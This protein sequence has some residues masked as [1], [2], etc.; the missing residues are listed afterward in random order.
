V[1]T[2]RVN[3][4]YLRGPVLADSKLV[5][6][7]VPGWRSAAVTV[8]HTSETVFTDQPST[9]RKAFLRTCVQTGAETAT[10]SAGLGAALTGRARAASGAARSARMRMW[11]SMAETSET[12]R[13]DNAQAR[14]LFKLN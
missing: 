4:G 6:L 2:W 9:G 14:P 5:K 7:F 11:R 12:L 8:L 3:A 10:A 1:R 13:R